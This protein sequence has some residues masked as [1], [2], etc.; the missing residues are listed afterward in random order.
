MAP[1][2]KQ[3]IKTQEN[4]QIRI[5]PRFFMVYL[6]GVEPA[7]FRVGVWRSIQLS[8]ECI[9]KKYYTAEAKKCQP[10]GEKMRAKRIWGLICRKMQV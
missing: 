2:S 5:I 4:P 6:T 8:Y 9:C 3:K 1:I 7:A 10:L